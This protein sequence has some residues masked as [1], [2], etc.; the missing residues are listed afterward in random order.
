MDIPCNDE[1]L[2]KD[3]IVRCLF[4]ILSVFWIRGTRQYIVG[5]SCSSNRPA[6]KLALTDVGAGPRQRIAIP[7]QKM[8]VSE[9]ICDVSDVWFYRK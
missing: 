4:R 6:R 9:F 7:C 8:N 2:A 3:V 1:P 5:P